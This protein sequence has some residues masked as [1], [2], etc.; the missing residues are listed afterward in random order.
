MKLL[1]KVKG[2]KGQQVWLYHCITL[3]GVEIPIMRW[4]NVLFDER[5]IQK[6]IM[7]NHRE[8]QQLIRNYDEA[9]KF[10]KRLE[11]MVD[12]VP[13]NKL[14]G[15]SE[16]FE[17]E[18]PFLSLFRKRTPPAPDKK[19]FEELE[20]FLKKGNPMTAFQHT[21]K[22]VESLRKEGKAVTHT[23][24]EAHIVPGS[25]FSNELNLT[26]DMRGS[27]PS[28][29]GQNNGGGNNNQQK[30]KGDRPWIYKET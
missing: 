4:K 21:I 16:A 19:D 24:P 23:I 14:V 8:E 7:S 12:K 9:V 29:G 11:D 3:F 30:D 20:R 18:A 22:T 28:G 5:A 25:E 2:R 26:T 13:E 1:V 10:R 15:S 27:M 6:E 17:I